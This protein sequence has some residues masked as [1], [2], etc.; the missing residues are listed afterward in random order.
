[1]SQST[2]AQDVSHCDDCIE[3]NADRAATPGRRPSGP[4]GSVLGGSLDSNAISRVGPAHATE[5]RADS[6]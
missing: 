5:R 1:V 6:D 3:T 2:H 4:K